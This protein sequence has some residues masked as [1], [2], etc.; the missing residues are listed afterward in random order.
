MQPN[1]KLINLELDYELNKAEKEGLESIVNIT[2]N[3]V[4]RAFSTNY[5]SGMDDKTSKLWRSI[6]RVL[7]GAIDKNVGFALFSSSDFDVVY[8]EIYKCK[9]DPMMARFVPYLYDELD[10]VKNRSKEDEEKVQDEMEALQ[11]SVKDLSSEAGLGEK[12]KQL[13]VASQ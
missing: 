5:S 2:R 12:N 7:D 11:R 6:R 13:K 4:N 3:L 10:L 8:S 9:F 1:T